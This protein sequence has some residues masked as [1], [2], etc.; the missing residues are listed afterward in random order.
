MGNVYRVRG[1]GKLV[2]VIHKNTHVMIDLTN[3][4]VV[5]LKDLLTAVREQALAFGIAWDRLRMDLLFR[6]PA[7]D[8][9]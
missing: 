1:K 4:E 7:E 6:L 2:M 9:P 5:L 8:E 3:A